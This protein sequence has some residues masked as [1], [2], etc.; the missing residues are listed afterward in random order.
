MLGLGKGEFY[1]EI[2]G[3]ERRSSKPLLFVAGIM[4]SLLSEAHGTSQTTLKL[5]NIKLFSP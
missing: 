5:S 3:S 2:R 4:R 1:E